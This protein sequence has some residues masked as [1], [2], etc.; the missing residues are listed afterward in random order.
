VIGLIEGRWLRSSGLSVAA[1]RSSSVP[2]AAIP[3]RYA[4]ALLQRQSVFWHAPEPVP[5][6]SPAR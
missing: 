6:A 4:I 1:S 3:V 5:S 2:G